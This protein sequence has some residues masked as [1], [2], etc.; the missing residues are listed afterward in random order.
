[1][2]TAETHFILRNLQKE[3]EILYVYMKMAN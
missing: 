3:E 2:Q 1:L